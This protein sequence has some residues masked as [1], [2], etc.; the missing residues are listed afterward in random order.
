LV[1]TA[2]AVSEAAVESLALEE[3]SMTRS[4][5]LLLFAARVAGVALAG[6]DTDIEIIVDNAA[7]VRLVSIFT[8]D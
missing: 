1:D 4:I 2:P 3:C 8:V 6:G 5:R 7:A